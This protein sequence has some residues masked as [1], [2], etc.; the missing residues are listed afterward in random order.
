MYLTPELGQYLNDHA[1][2]KVNEAIIEYNWVAPYWFVSNFDQTYGEG[3]IQPI[4]VPNSIFQAKALIL[5]ES[6]IDL[7][8]YLDVPGVERG[9]FYY[10][11]NLV[12]VIQASNA[13][14]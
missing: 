12:A 1:I 9:D 11:Q 13:N 4:F 7:V 8:R 3:A 5:K 2:S 6:F 10:I 14:P